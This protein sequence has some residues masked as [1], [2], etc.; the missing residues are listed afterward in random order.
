MSSNNEEI[1]R[2]IYVTVLKDAR[3]THTN[4]AIPLSKSPHTI[5]PNKH[6]ETKCEPKVQSTMELKK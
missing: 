3:V 5:F 6:L 2:K 1:R 4:N